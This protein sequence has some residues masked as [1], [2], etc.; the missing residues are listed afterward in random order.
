MARACFT[1][2]NLGEAAYLE[3][4][5]W[6]AQLVKLQVLALTPALPNDAERVAARVRRRQ[7]GTGVIA[8][9]DH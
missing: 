2:D 3:R 5:E 7:R 1:F 6:P 4:G 8:E 9:A